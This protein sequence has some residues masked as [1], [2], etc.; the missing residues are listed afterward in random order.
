MIDLV[1]VKFVLLGMVLGFLTFWGEGMFLEG[2]EGCLA[3]VRGWVWGWD[4]D[5]DWV[6]NWISLQNFFSLSFKWGPSLL[7]LL[8]FR[9]MEVS[10][11]SS[12]SSGVWCFFPPFFFLFLSGGD[13]VCLFS[14]VISIVVIGLTVAV[15]SVV[16]VTAAS[17]IDVLFW[18]D[19]GFFPFQT[20]WVHPSSLLGWSPGSGFLPGSVVIVAVAV[21]VV[22]VV[23]RIAVVAVVAIAVGILVV[24]G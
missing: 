4:C 23:V 12:C 3:G 1:G 21:V 22:V 17:T 6:W 20:T 7:S 19:W 9:L 16:V 5:C 8:L 18:G 15:V 10:I 2:D 13:I 11:D 24:W 14:V